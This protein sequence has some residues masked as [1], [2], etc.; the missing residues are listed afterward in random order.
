MADHHA[1]KNGVVREGLDECPE[2]LH[3][4][5]GHWLCGLAH[6]LVRFLNPNLIISARES[7]KPSQIS[8][9]SDHVQ[10]KHKHNHIDSRTKSSAAGCRHARACC[11]LRL[12]PQDGV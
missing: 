4:Q 7:N 10:V 11:A 3:E 12:V 8:V 1:S 9:H 2:W 6:L 5:S